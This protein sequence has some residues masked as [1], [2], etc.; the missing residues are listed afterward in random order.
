MKLT[1]WEQRIKRAEDLA[2]THPSAA[3]V[4]H[5]YRHVAELQKDLYLYF[6]AALCDVKRNS[7]SLSFTLDS[8]FDLVLPKF[9]QFLSNLEA[10]G[11]QPIATCARNLNSQGFDRCGKVLASYREDAADLQPG[12]GKAESLLTWL[13][14][15][16]YAESLAD[17]GKAHP[18][19][20]RMSNC[21]F[22]SA[23]PLVGVLRQEGDGAK[24]SLICS[25]CST[26]WACGRLV[27]PSCGEEAVD[28]LSVYTTALF[29]Y[30]RVETCDTCSH[31]IKTV[32]LTKN[33]LAV[34]V[35]DE[36][37]TIPLNFWAYEHGYVKLQPNLLGI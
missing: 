29:D 21:P 18:S 37:A 26:E 6:E 36:L 17:H 35:V 27:C 33:G 4:L 5:F 2:V 14:L 1:K 7:R 10:M 31:Y 19:P 30:I 9:R 15:Q 28:K 23:R 16:P 8:S 32:D 25:V 12:L 20:T 22:C 34:P 11:A 3:E 24:R 13:F